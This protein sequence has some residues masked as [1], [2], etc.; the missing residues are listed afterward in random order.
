MA[1]ATAVAS[2]P[3]AK[4]F[5][6]TNASSASGTYAEAVHLRNHLILN[7]L[8][9]E[10]IG[11]GSHRTGDGSGTAAQTGTALGVGSGAWN[12]LQDSLHPP[13]H[14]LAEVRAPVGGRHTYCA[15]LGPCCPLDAL[16]EFLGLIASKCRRLGLGLWEQQ[17]VWLH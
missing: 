17:Q 11:G 3:W 7:T 2:S 15:E 4:Q 6:A 5:T 14:S 9:P 12:N 8:R 10:D 1:A 13:W 16:E